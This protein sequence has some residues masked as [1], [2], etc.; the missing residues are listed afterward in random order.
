MVKG[1]MFLSK[2]QSPIGL[3]VFSGAILVILSIYILYQQ[4]QTKEGFDGKWIISEAELHKKNIAEENTRHKNYKGKSHLA[5]VTIKKQLKK[6]IDEDPNL[7]EEVGEVISDEKISDKLDK[8]LRSRPVLNKVKGVIATP[9]IT[10]QIEEIIHNK[11]SQNKIDS[12]TQQMN[13]LKSELKKEIK[14]QIA[15]IHINIKQDIKKVKTDAKKNVETAIK[16]A[17]VQTALEVKKTMPAES[18]YDKILNAYNKLSEKN[19]NAVEQKRRDLAEISSIRKQIE[20]TEQSQRINSEMATKLTL[21][22]E[23]IR[24]QQA[25]AVK[26][27]KESKKLFTDLVKHNLAVEEKHKLLKIKVAKDKKVCDEHRT[28]MKRLTIRLEG[29]NSEKKSAEDQMKQLK[30]QLK[31]TEE[32]SSL[33]AVLK[34]QITQLEKVKVQLEKNQADLKKE[35]QQISDKEAELRSK[36]Q[37]IESQLS[38]LEIDNKKLEKQI[39]DTDA[40]NK[41]E[42]ESVTNFAKLIDEAKDKIAVRK[43]TN[44]QLTN[45]LSNLQKQH[46]KLTAKQTDEEKQ[47]GNL[48]VDAATNQKKI[49][50]L[51]IIVN[52][53]KIKP[54]ENPIGNWDFTKGSLKD[55]TEKFQSET[56]G[57]VPFE[58][59]L[60]KKAALFTEQNHIK[61]TGSISTND[62]K[63]I[64]MMIYVINNPAPWPR[65]WEFTNSQLGGNW[66]ADSIFGVISPSNG[67]GFYS[68]KDCNGPNFLSN[69]GDLPKSSWQH[70]A[71]VYSEKLDEMMM[72]VNGQKVG[73]WAEPNTKRLQNRTFSNLYIMQCVE[74]F[75][76]NI[77][78]AWFRMFDYVM[79]E[80][81]VI[82][83]MNNE[84]A[85]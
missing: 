76:K 72:Y 57:N 34:S 78:V 29:T 24:K 56:V 40:K 17:E 36:N 80:K 43:S 68:M 23:T 32:N 22:V 62:F 69:K 74:R 15:E 59:Y 12:L 1:E 3:L 6:L 19:N 21:S 54:K 50:D 18:T 31:A 39:A 41:L 83:D 38:A 67:V 85:T 37:K 28:E 16:K 11:P 49:T 70:L 82:K 14:T 81:D 61:I 77:A 64:T 79:V 4:S 47:L 75:N 35:L 52:S 45:E 30:S 66:C 46:D 48:E 44:T 20:K 53:L 51:Q 25:D 60:G 27:L 42:Q 58:T 73:Q 5:T 13:Q 71:F 26:Q 8:T 84:W 33:S 10:R 63:S 7:I 2:I 55:R 65:L 9:Q